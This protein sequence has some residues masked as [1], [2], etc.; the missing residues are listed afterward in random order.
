MSK[1]RIIPTPPLK[2]PSPLLS[3]S[4]PAHATKMKK[5]GVYSRTVEFTDYGPFASFGP[6]YDSTGA[7]LSPIESTMILNPT[8]TVGLCLIIGQDRDG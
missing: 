4:L 7:S 3:K 8:R 2:G 6:A 1:I 5:T